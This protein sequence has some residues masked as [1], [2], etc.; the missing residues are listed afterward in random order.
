LDR[1]R[2]SIG[3]VRSAVLTVRF[4]RTRDVASWIPGGHD[5]PFVCTVTIED[6]R[7]RR[8]ERVAE[9]H[10]A[11]PDDFADPNP[12]LRPRRAIVTSSPRVLERVE[13]PLA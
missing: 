6:D 4:D 12:D 13:P 8:H 2:L 3:V 11:R 5:N 10:C 7:G 1:H 9:G